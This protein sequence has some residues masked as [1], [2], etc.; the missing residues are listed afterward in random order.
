[1]RFPF[2]GLLFV[3]ILAGSAVLAGAQAKAPSGSAV[4]NPPA[5]PDFEACDV[6][7]VPG[8]GRCATY[9]VYENRAAGKGR[10]IGLHIL[11]LP[12]LS[13][14]PAPDPVFWLHGGPGAAA[15][16]TASAAKG[17]FLEG[18]RAEHDLVFVDQR[19]TGRSH[20]LSCD[21]GDDS[22]DLAGYFGKLLPPELVRACRQ[23]L[24]KDADLALYTTSIAMDDL[25]DVRAALGYETIDIVAAS[26]GSIAAQAYIRQHGDRVRAAFLTGVATPGIKQ[27][28][29]F[30]RGAQE[31][32][33]L[34][35]RDCDADAACRKAFPKLEQEFDAVLA[36]FDRGALDVRMIDP[37]N[38]KEK[39]VKLERESYVERLR[40]MLYTTTFASF[41]PCIVHSAFQGDWVPFE[42]VAIA[43]NPGSILSR[44]MYMTI[45]CS[46]GVPF[47]TEAEIRE[48]ARG[49]F[50]GERRV[51]A[52]QEACREWVRGN[53]PASFT[54][55]V[56]SSV[57]LL[58]F[59]GEADG[60][61]PQWLGEGAVKYLANGRQIEVK[62]Y[63][64]QVDS[65][66]MWKVLDQFI[67]T[68]SVRDLDT[69]CVADIHRPPFA[70][71]I[72]AAF[73]LGGGRRA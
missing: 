42:S 37:V 44:G 52:H 29:P 27:P 19:G 66:C 4:R 54:E 25:D 18:L 41:V 69:S 64:H 46:E 57:P 34:L 72:P 22:T 49:T 1:M 70:T 7:N 11:V 56:R 24:E 32:L 5:K 50:V 12:A 45:T 36:R 28:L 15:S 61:T 38:G 9:E 51:R 58:M 53:V 39:S 31:A 60:S 43:Y 35:Y 71:E 55:P 68:A 13:K 8:G 20:P 63:G 67:R 65:P 48:Q 10:K 16:D 30:A 47:I 6:P 40:L 17:G 26:Y 33:D 23:L 21:V 73:S 2:R 59:S 3:S 14:T 62:H